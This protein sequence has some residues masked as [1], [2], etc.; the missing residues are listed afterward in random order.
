MTLIFIGKAKDVS[1][2]LAQLQ[3]DLRGVI[4]SGKQIRWDSRRDFHDDCLEVK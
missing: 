4:P 1:Q 2:Y 3:S